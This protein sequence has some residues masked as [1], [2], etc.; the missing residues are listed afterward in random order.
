MLERE[1]LRQRCADWI[2]VS[3]QQIET[4]EYATRE[5]GLDLYALQ[6]ER[7]AEEA[8]AE[9]RTS[10]TLRAQPQTAMALAKLSP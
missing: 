10:E 3:G 2:L 4:L 9:R 6:L 5:L 7:L 1:Q 8:A